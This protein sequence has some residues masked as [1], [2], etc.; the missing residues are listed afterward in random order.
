MFVTWINHLVYGNVLGLYLLNIL[1]FD[2]LTFDQTS[3]IDMMMPRTI[4]YELIRVESLI[5]YILTAILQQSDVSCGVV[6]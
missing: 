2:C 1:Y 3:I 5:V 4:N 6:P